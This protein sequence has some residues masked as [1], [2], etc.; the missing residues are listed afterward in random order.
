MKKNKGFT[1]IELLAV[2]IILGIIM[3]IAIPSVTRYINDSRRDTYIDTAKEY[4][5]GATLLINSGEVEFYDKDTTLYIPIEC[6]SLERGGDS[7]FGKF[8]PAYVVTI[9]TGDGYNYY[10]TSR[11]VSGVG[12]FLTKDKYLDKKLIKTDI[13]EGDITTSISIGSRK[14]VSL[15]ENC[16][17]VGE[18]TEAAFKVNEDIYSSSLDDLA[19]GINA[20]ATLSRTWFNA[21]GISKNKVK[22]IRIVPK[23]DTRSGS[24]DASAS[25][26]GSV[27]AY[28]ENNGSMYDIYITA[29]GG[30]LAP[31]NSSNLF[32]M[33]SSAEV[34]DIKYLNTK[35]V[36]NMN[37][38]FED[39]DTIT[40]LD[41][42]HFNTSKVTTMIGLFNNIDSVTS[43]DL[44]SFD[45]SNVTNMQGLFWDDSSLVRIDVSNFDTS[46]V[47][48][49]S[50]MFAATN[51]M[52][53]EEII[54]LN[55]FDTSNV[56]NMYGMFTNNMKLRT[57]DLSSWNTSKVTD[58]TIMFYRSPL[59]TTI[60]ASDK[61]D[62][63]HVTESEYMFYSCNSIVGGNGTVYQT[64]KIE[65]RTPSGGTR[66]RYECDKRFAVIDK[67]GQIGFFTAK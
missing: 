53:L 47:T 62:T 42:S 18:K 6:V 60:Y 39:C 37:S 57:L 25:S 26:D 13:K 48:D 65:E 28:K 14:Y 12:I 21:S 36:T 54:G 23:K 34:I 40:E 20:V 10:W 31:P 27:M 56:T 16:S 63:S 9:Y 32:S 4:I 7:P 58:M 38:M 51:S 2:I 8:S 11:D 50:Y 67:E 64:V 44:S 35:N 49:M 41:V 3:L 19:P 33:F 24:W 30:V 45:T 52:N 46:K 55:S 17:T 1:L 15:L 29:D 22:S 61:F 43:L 59:L 66:I 5:K